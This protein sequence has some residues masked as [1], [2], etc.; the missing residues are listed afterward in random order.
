MDAK[1]L[2]YLMYYHTRTTSDPPDVTTSRE[3]AVIA[4]NCL[5]A[6]GL[7]R[8]SEPQDPDVTFVITDKGKVFVSRLLKTPMP[9]ATWGYPDE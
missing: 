1:E 5:V 6:H 9:T 4:T 3:A 8:D 7:L 2:Y